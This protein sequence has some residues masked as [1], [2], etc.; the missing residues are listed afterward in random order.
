MTNLTDEQ[1]QIKDKEDAERMTDSVQKEA[2][3]VEVIKGRRPQEVIDLRKMSDAQQ[4]QHLFSFFPSDELKQTTG[5]DPMGMADA[6]LP[7]AEV[8]K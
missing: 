7:K 5:D 1:Q 8:R 4:M 2:A 3:V 6:V